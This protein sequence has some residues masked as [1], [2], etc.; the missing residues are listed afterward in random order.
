DRQDRELC[1]LAAEARRDGLNSDRPCSE[2]VLQVALQ[3]LL[4]A[5]LERLRPDLEGLVRVAVR[6]AAPLDDRVTAPDRRRLGAHLRQRDERRRLER[7][8]RTALEV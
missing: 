7:D 4:L 1:D 8:L 5:G 6:R 3:V 2:P